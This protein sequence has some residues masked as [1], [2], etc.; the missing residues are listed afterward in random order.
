MKKKRQERK[1]RQDRKRKAGAR[2]LQK[3]HKKRKKQRQEIKEKELQ[4]VIKDL[5][6]P[7]EGDH[8]LTLKKKWIEK[9]LSA[10]SLWH[11]QLAILATTTYDFISLGGNSSMVKNAAT[12]SEHAVS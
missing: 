11:K 4:D 2:N 8:I 9:V 1:E 12:T 6:Y 3:Y 5:I 7:K 10:K